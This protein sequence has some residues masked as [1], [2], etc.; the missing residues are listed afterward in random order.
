MV[1]IGECHAFGLVFWDE[2]A[3]SGYLSLEVTLVTRL[4]EVSVVLSAK[5]IGALHMGGG[6]GEVYG[7]PLLV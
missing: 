5:V 6:K 3:L 7:F 4:N 2:T 1:L